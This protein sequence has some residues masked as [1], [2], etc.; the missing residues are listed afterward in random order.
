MINYKSET[1]KFS[2]SGLR[3]LYPEDINPS[4]IPAIVLSWHKTLPK[5][6]IAIA[7]DSRP[8]GPAISRLAEGVLLSAGREI[9]DLGVV[10]TPT[11]KAFINKKN[12]AGG[13]MISA[14]HNPMTYNAFKFIG[15]NGFFFNQAQ[16][17][18]F[19]KNIDSKQKLNW[20]DMKT[21][22]Q[23]IIS[24][25]KEAIEKHIE[26][27]LETTKLYQY[28]NSLK[29]IRVAI[30]PV[31]GCAC[32][33]V[34]ILL[35]TAGV[36]YFS[37]HGKIVPNFPRN[38][39]PVPNALKALGSLVV[40]K[41][42]HIGFAFD[43]DADRL[44]LVGPDGK[45]LGEEMTLPLSLLK[46]L[47]ERNGDIVINLST[48]WYNN[49]VAA[50]YNKKTIRSAVGEANV[51]KKMVQKKAAFGGEGNGGVIDPKVPSFGRD[52]LTGVAYILSLL[53][54]ENNIYQIT[55]TFPAL[56]MKKLTLKAD[57]KTLTNLSNKLI[58][59]FKNFK[60]NKEDGLH[61]SGKNGLPWIHLRPSNTE[62][63][64]RLIVEAETEKE[65]NSILSD[66]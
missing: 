58:K 23:N 29:N 3:G 30:D 38:P 26:S 11:I 12:L 32:N 22:R 33:I 35:K 5:G 66:I 10:P 54:E 31:G 13:L 17:E 8:T 64:A 44:A 48:S 19:K 60:I 20:G 46:A 9:Y 27:V 55:K 52:S 1:L 24:A 47:P 36:Q 57:K 63:I 40:E 53:A 37:V 43:P 50:N 4:N 51:V 2:V 39:E 45:P 6:P 59:N 42:C 25:E 21:A 7:R 16:N 65:L 41:N 18:I 34:P 15:K 28:F 56:K 61:L 14:S 49:F 62:P